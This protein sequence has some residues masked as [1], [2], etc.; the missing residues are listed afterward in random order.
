M[1][2]IFF[3]MLAFYLMTI[4]TDNELVK[5]IRDNYEQCRN[6]RTE[7]IYILTMLNIDSSITCERI[8]G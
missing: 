3:F 5:L 2:N 8:E 4:I 7:I 6:D 1:K